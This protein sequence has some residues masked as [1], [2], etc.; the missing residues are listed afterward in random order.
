[1]EEFHILNG[2][3]LA[4]QLAGVMLPG[5]FIVCRECLVDGPV[6]SNSLDDFFRMRAGYISGMT[7]L[8][9]EEYYNKSEKEFQKILALPDNSKI[10]L[11]FENDLFCQV[12]LWFVLSLLQDRVPQNLFRVFPQIENGQDKW[13][14]FGIA[15]SGSLN[16]AYKNAVHFNVADLQFGKLLWEAY[17]NNDLNILQKLGKIKSELFRD[18]EPVIAAHVERFSVPGRPE[19]IVKEIISGGTMD[20]NEVMTEFSKREGVYGFSDLQIKN[21]WN[22]MMQTM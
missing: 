5:S 11:W 21:M 16:E 4:E 3:C 18:L 15:T 17:C 1:M 10:F 6:N 12:N 2:D 7:G 20:F 22:K 13:K 19:R 9:Q 8:S 14:G